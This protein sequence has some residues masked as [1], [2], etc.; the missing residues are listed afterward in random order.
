VPEAVETISYNIPAFRLRK[1]FIYYAAFKD[2]IS[3]FPPLKDEP[4]LAQLLKPYRNA[5]G[6]LLFGHDEPMP[7]GLVT[8]VILALAKSHSAPEGR[9]RKRREHRR[10]TAT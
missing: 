2:H 6:N 8:R 1:V 4:K 10:E 3:I 7:Y 9:Q 5:K